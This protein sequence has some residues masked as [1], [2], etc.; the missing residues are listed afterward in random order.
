M[1]R[2]LL[3][4]TAL[5]A[6]AFASAA[7]AVAPHDA[8][9]LGM[10]ALAQLG[11]AAP[12]MLAFGP[13]GV[14]LRDMKTK[15]AGLMKQA[16]DLVALETQTDEQRTQ[17][18]AITAQIKGVNAQIEQTEFLANQEA[19]MDAVGGVVIPAAATIRVTENVADDPR[20]GF[21]SF[22]DFAR[23]VRVGPAADK[24]LGYLAAAPSTASNEAAGAD[25]GFLVPPQ[26]SQELFRLSLGEDSLLPLT[27]NTELSNTNSMVFPKTEQTPWGTNG[28]RA[29]WQVEASAATATKLALGTQT[30]RLHKMM[31]L[32]PVTDELLADEVALASEL[33]PLIG[34]N[35]RWK[36]NE[37]ILFGNGNGQPQGAVNSGA[38]IVVAKDSGQSTLTLTAT[39]LANM[40]SRLPPGSFPRSIWLINPSVLPALF[41]M[42]LGNY[43]I[44]LPGGANTGGIQMN[45][46]GTLLGRPIVVSQHAAS[47]T[48]QGDVMLHDLSYYRTNTAAG[49]IQTATSMH[50]Y[51]DADATAFRVTFRLDGG[52][53]IA[54]PISP[55][56]GSTTLSPFLALQAR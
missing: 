45:P 35:I 31:A 49:G 11:H 28:V 47:F 6:I 33:L 17:F 51:F 53:K 20:R 48:S 38:V 15:K 27:S 10:L 1:K 56:K 4:A 22:G 30:L 41:T 21:R 7:F 39:N 23:S 24:R 29:Y 42:T 40:M 19:G 14:A 5:A 26:F 9:M 37:A 12:V 3:V 55:A 54:A 25:G 34:D 50:L 2:S 13:F 8:H 32:C 16:A 52:S 46:Y 43:P 36:T 44:Y 18:A